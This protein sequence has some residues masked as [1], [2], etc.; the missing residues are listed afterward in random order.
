MINFFLTK[1]MIKNISY[2]I[3]N[4]TSYL[5]IKNATKKGFQEAYEGDSVNL[6]YPN[7]KTRRGRVGKQI[8]QTIT[9]NNNMG[10]VVNVN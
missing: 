5:K 4:N 1:E 8:S 9:T 7:S 10:V 3:N 6:S 2:T